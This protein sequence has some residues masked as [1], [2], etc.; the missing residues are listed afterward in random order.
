MFRHAMQTCIFAL[1][2][3]FYNILASIWGLDFEHMWYLGEQKSSVETLQ[4]FLENFSFFRFPS[5]SSVRVSFLRLGL[6][7]LPWRD[8]L[9]FHFTYPNVWILETL[10]SLERV[11]NSI[12]YFL[13]FIPRPQSE[14]KTIRT[15]VKFASL[16][17]QGYFW[18]FLLLCHLI[19]LAQGLF[20]G[21]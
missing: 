21:Q 9:K 20:S 11:F 14:K 15:S 16:P 3:S 7:L 18:E 12:L 6:C 10:F 5:P 19:H 1:P 8:R 13:N 4:S 17:D 2:D